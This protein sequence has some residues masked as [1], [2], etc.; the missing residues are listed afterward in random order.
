MHPRT[1]SGI[2]H[3]RFIEDTVLYIY[4]FANPIG[5]FRNTGGRDEQI[6]LDRLIRAKTPY[7]PLEKLFDEPKEL[8]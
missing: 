1:L 4:N 7:E 5:D 3:S 2:N 8:L 6:R